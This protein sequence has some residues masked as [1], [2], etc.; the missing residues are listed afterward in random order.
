MSSKSNRTKWIII[1]AFLGV[2]FGFVMSPPDVV[3]Q[4]IAVPTGAIIFA[5]GVSLVL[6]VIKKLNCNNRE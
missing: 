4:F 1:A 3:C 5:G 6:W 2:I